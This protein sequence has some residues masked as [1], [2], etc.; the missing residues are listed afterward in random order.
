MAARGGSEVLIRRAHR[1]ALSRYRWIW[2]LGSVVMQPEVNHGDCMLAFWADGGH[3]TAGC[4]DKLFI[5]KRWH[6]TRLSSQEPR[7]AA[8]RR[9]RRDH[10]APLVRGYAHTRTIHKNNE[11][12]KRR[13]IR[14][15]FDQTNA[16]L[17]KRTSA[18]RHGR[19]F[20]WCIHKVNLT[21]ISSTF[22]FYIYM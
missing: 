12:K 7:R 19:S 1:S 8:G 10:S 21:F 2:P 18:D 9:A 4:H 14:S 11:T 16:R 22:K 13:P 6:A 17:G 20:P 15:A 5:H 3:G